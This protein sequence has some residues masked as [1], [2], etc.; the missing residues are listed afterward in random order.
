MLAA[1][2]GH[3][4]VQRVEELHLEELAPSPKNCNSSP[5]AA[6]GLQFQ[7]VEWS[8]RMMRGRN[9]GLGGPRCDAGTA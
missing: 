2:G 6:G 9:N 8:A 3:A 5:V 7:N 1:D 4:H